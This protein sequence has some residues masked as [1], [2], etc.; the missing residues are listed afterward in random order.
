ML[1][2]LTKP[3]DVD[4]LMVSGF[5]WPD[6]LSKAKNLNRD[7]I[8]PI[9]E[10]LLPEG[11]WAILCGNLAPHGAV[12]K[13][14]AVAPDMRQHRGPARMF[15]GEHDA[16][17]AL[18]AGEVQGGEVLIARYEGARSGR[19][20]R[21]MLVPAMMLAGRDLG[22]SVSLVTDGR[23]SDGSRGACVGHVSPEAAD[24]GPIALVEDGDQIE[25][26]IPAR[27]LH[28]HVSTEDLCRRRRSWRPL[29]RQ[30]RGYL[31]RYAASVGPSHE[32]CLFQ[33]CGSMREIADDTAPSAPHV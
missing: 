4:Q 32:G 21:E 27:L 5:R 33:P 2:E 22:R 29:E 16:V 28:L 8:R 26:D 12:V 19:G 6:H 24:G 13:Q 10:P 23:F 25:I 17:A 9:S 3:I 31:A 15:D 1:K 7:A 30:L 14:S 18:A 20:M 11:G